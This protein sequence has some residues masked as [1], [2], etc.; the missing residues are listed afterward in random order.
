[1]VDGNFIVFG[2]VAFIVSSILVL[3][4]ASSSSKRALTLSLVPPLASTLVFVGILI[5]VFGFC[6]GSAGCSQ[7][8]QTSPLWL[9]LLTFILIAG[10]LSPK[11]YN[12]LGRSWRRLVSELIVPLS[13]II[14]FSIFIGV[15]CSLIA[16]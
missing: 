8:I 4:Q 12:I 1:M 6:F 14:V 10:R 11:I 2:A 3:N 5:L 15:V 13:A 9:A 16:G 7:V